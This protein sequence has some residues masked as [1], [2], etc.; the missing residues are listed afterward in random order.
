MLQPEIQ[1]LKAEYLLTFNSDEDDELS[2]Q[3]LELVAGG[4]GFKPP[5]SGPSWLDD[6]N[7]PN[8]RAFWMNP[9]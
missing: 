9:N 2:E 5:K 1:A 4:N 8:D 6:P 7:C 3:E